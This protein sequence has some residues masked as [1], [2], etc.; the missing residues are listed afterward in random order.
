[1]N[2]EFSRN[3]RVSGPGKAGNAKG[4]IMNMSSN[5]SEFVERGGHEPYIWE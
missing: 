4:T 1:L 2:H 3:E 5:S